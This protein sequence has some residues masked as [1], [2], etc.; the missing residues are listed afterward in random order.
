MF[1]SKKPSAFSLIE[2]SIVILIIGIIIAGV[3]QSS[4]LVVMFKKQSAQ[5]LTKSSPVN[6]I[7]NLAMWLETSMEDS[8][9]VDDSDSSVTRWNDINPQSTSKVDAYGGTPP[10]LVENQIN[11]LPGVTFAD[12]AKR[13]TIDPDGSGMSFLANTN[14]T[15]FV[16]EKRVV[17][18][19]IN[20][21]SF[22]FLR[23]SGSANSTNLQYGYND[24][25]F[26][27]NDWGLDWNIAG[28]TLS[29]AITPRLHTLVFDQAVGKTYSMKSAN[30]AAYTVTNDG[31]LG[32]PL[33]SYAGAAIGGDAGSIDGIMA[34]MIVFTRALKNSEIADIEAYL[35]KKYAI[36]VLP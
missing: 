19:D 31:F 24:D 10:I 9:T 30:S 35:E 13:L 7:K 12:S 33:V 11:G 18:G 34:E 15:I 17:G 3:T 28:V 27:S 21:N 16:V 20:G 22:F 25:G 2:L 36:K 4:R 6:S 1:Y 5:T 26:I 29:A 32:H 14:Y 23:G 8:V